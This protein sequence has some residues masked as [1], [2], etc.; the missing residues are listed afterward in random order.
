MPVWNTYQLF[1]KPVTKPFCWL[2]FLLWQS[3]SQIRTEVPNSSSQ[4]I[5]GGSFLVPYCL[6][7]LLPFPLWPNQVPQAVSLFFLRNKFLLW[8]HE[9]YWLNDPIV[10]PAIISIYYGVAKANICD[11]TG[12]NND[13]IQKLLVIGVRISPQNLDACFLP[14]DSVFDHKLVICTDCQEKVSIGIAYSCLPM[15]SF[16]RLNS[17]TTL[18]LTCPPFDVTDGFIET[19]IGL[20]YIIHN[21]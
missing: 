4:Q 1:K 2:F 18:A 17:L 15:I 12:I 6:G 14:E 10:S 9:L 19:V 11:V 8:E 13:I 16:Q 20:L 21:I 7:L 5:V 3:D